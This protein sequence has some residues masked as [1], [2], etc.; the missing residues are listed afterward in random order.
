MRI[1]AIAFFC[2]V[3][4]LGSSCAEECS[5][6]DVS[7]ICPMNIEYVCGSDRITYANKC[8]LCSQNI[9]RSRSKWIQVAS[10]GHC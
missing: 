7:P 6:S 5:E 1:V 4:F 9:G 8:H 10:G 2:L 3:L